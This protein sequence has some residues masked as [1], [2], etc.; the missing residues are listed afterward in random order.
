MWCTSH[1]PISRLALFLALAALLGACRTTQRRVVRPPNEL[2]VYNRGARLIGGVR[3]KPCGAPESAY[4]WVGSTVPAGQS[5]GLPLHPGCVD[6]SVVSL[7]GEELGRQF[8][9]NMIP[10]STWEIR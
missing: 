6:L 7:E 5:L 8:N 3:M 10:G 1:S 9:L 2:R 4:Q